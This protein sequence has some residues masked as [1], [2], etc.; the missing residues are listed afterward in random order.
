MVMVSHQ[1]IAVA[2]SVVARSPGFQNREQRLPVLSVEIDGLASVTLRGHMVEGSGVGEPSRSGHVRRIPSK[3]MIQDLTPFL[4]FPPLFVCPQLE[5][6]DAATSPNSYQ[7]QA[8]MAIP[9][10]AICR[11]CSKTGSMRK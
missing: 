11:E 5:A 10:S 3:L 7:G 4:L 8:A 2:E 6:T 1:T 9:G